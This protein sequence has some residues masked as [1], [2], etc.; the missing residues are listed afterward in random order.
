MSRARGNRWRRGL[1]WALAVAFAAVIALFMVAFQQGELTAQIARE[2]LLALSPWWFVLIT[3]I[4]LGGVRYLT[5][6]FVPAAAGSG[7][8]QV[9]AVT[10]QPISPKRAGEK[11]LLSPAGA[12]FK[13]VAVSLSMAG[14]GT[15]G[16]EGPA[17][18][19]GASLLSC[20][21]RLS[22]KV[23]IPHRVIAIAGAATGLAAAFSTPLAGVMY[24]FEE[25]LWRRRYRAIALVPLCV[26]AAAITGWLVT[27][28][29]QFFDVVVDA[30]NTP[31]WW[32]MLTLAAFCGVGAGAM[33]W[34]MM[35]ALPR[36]LPTPRSPTHGALIAGA[37]GLVLALLGV[38]SNGLSMGS[39]NET[40]AV[41][42]DPAASI[43]TTM[44][45][46]GLTKALATTLTFGT[47]VPAGILTPS[48][49][50]GGGFG[51]DFAALTNL[52]EMRQVLV[53][54][55][56]TAFLSGVI[57]TP[58][59]VALMVAEMSGASALGVEL[60]VCALIGGWSAK[61]LCREGV[62]EVALHRILKK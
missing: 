55:G 50:I 2:R 47:G 38:W 39:G 54:F 34:L 35:F 44:M 40:S 27:R 6:R 3:P 46:V 23:V 16:R 60:L 1:A 42:L 13:A 48:L 28:D 52:D 17:I 24:A 36:I 41:L 31:P 49:A 43:E 59:T 8:P 14:G 15:V 10:E 7:I 32:S 33:G 12:L 30:V 9:M 26:A 61:A 21:S 4:T 29:R 58:V 57:R 51:Y 5:L 19:V 18:Q 37:I 11:L 25:F 56:M 20:G 22:G 45:S 53:L 62:Y